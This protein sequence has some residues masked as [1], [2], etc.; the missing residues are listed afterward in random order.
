LKELKKN[1]L[2]RLLKGEGLNDTP[3][4]FASLRL[5]HATCGG[6]GPTQ[7]NAEFKVATQSNTEL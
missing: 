2:L 3:T 6:L 7:D 4:L 5:T 1:S